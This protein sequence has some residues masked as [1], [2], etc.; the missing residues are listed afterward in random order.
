MTRDQVIVRI[1][2]WLTCIL[3]SHRLCFCCL[4]GI[5]VFRFDLCTCTCNVRTIRIDSLI[6]GQRSPCRSRA[7]VHGVDRGNGISVLV[8][9]CQQG[10]LRPE[11]SERHLLGNDD[12][13]SVWPLPKM[14]RLRMR[15]CVNA[16]ARDGVS[17]TIMRNGTRA[18]ATIHDTWSSRLTRL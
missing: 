9:A 8:Q 13:S 17:Y 11:S 12:Q 15:H 5:D 7:G 10:S 16:V 14:P 4:S 2:E 6:Y 1:M 3:R 18:V